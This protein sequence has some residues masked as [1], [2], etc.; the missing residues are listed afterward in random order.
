[1][2]II[3]QKHQLKSIK[4]YVILFTEVKMTI[5]DEKFCKV[6]FA[7]PEKEDIK[8]F[9]GFI[10]KENEDFVIK[11]K[12]TEII[13]DFFSENGRILYVLIDNNK[14]TFYEIDKY[15]FTIY[16]EYLVYNFYSKKMLYGI[17]SENPNEEKINELVVDFENLN[18]LFSSHTIEHK[19]ENRK[20]I[21]DNDAEKIIYETDNFFIDILIWHPLKLSH[22]FVDI[23]TKTNIKFRY[24]TSINIFDALNNLDYFLSFVTFCSN[25]VFDYNKVDFFAGDKKFSLEKATTITTPNL[26]LFALSHANIANFEQIIKSIYKNKQFLQFIF[27]QYTKTSVQQKNKLLNADVFAQWIS[28]IELVFDKYFKK[29]DIKNF[30]ETIANLKT[31]INESTELSEEQKKIA[32]N[33]ITGILDNPLKEK[34]VKIL[35]SANGIYYNIDSTYLDKSSTFINKILNTRNLG[36]HPRNYKPKDIFTQLEIDKL[37]CLFKHVVFIVICKNLGVENFGNYYY[38]SIKYFF[39]IINYKR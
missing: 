39:D 7:N 11:F 6:Y 18:L 30:E 8:S 17:F 29:I 20:N 5:T 9:E 38:E 13:D 32:I 19:I 25:N 23:K 16:N 28:V 2:I 4:I 1:M 14:C 33:R 21:F 10:N 26:N 15:S 24:K 34:I 37:N 22:D 36:T 3:A 27:N 31:I 35:E 12:S